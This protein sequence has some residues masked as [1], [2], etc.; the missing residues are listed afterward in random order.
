MLPQIFRTEAKNYF[1]KHIELL[2]MA[3]FDEFVVKSLDEIVFLR[4]HG[5]GDIPMVSDANLYVMNHLARE[6]MQNLGISRM[7]LPLELN[8]R[9]L[10]T[11]GCENME[12]Y[13]YGYLPAMVSAQ[14]IVRT[15]K[16]CTKQPELLIMR[17]RT[18]KDLPVKNH[19]RFCYNTIYNIS[20]LSLLGQEKLI[21]RLAPGILRLA[22]TIETAQQMTEIL[23][24][25]AD[26]FLYGRDTE[27]PCRDFTRGHFK[28]GVE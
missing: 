16:G 10:E 23:N 9:E 17:D 8:S 7:T 22:F 1:Q 3:G 20:P 28:R 4:E 11:L 6:Q 27:N 13:V 25:F 18:G 19:C 12:L 24:A 21:K 5:L 15:T 2:Q 26:H 14:C